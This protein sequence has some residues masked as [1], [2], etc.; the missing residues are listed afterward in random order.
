[1]SSS[2]FNLPPF[3]TTVLLCEV[4]HYVEPGN[5]KTLLQQNINSLWPDDLIRIMA[6]ENKKYIP[7]IHA[8]YEQCIIPTGSF[9]DSVWFFVRTHK[10]TQMCVSA[11][12]FALI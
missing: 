6:L 12:L 7:R 8:A 4:T 3:F 1:M 10:N 9:Y 11:I 5:Y 2:H